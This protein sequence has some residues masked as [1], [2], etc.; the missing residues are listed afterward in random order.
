MHIMRATVLAALI[1]AASVSAQAEAP[2]P[3]LSYYALR[4][5]GEDAVQKELKL[6]ATQQ[7]K[8]ADLAGTPA[9]VRMSGWRRDGKSAAEM[10]AEIEK[11]LAF[12]KPDQRARLR[13]IGLQ[14]AEA[15]TAGRRVLASDK[16]LHDELKLTRAQREKLEGGAA[17]ADVLDAVQ[18]KALGAMK[19]TPMAKAGPWGE[20]G[21]KDARPKDGWGKSDKEKK[22]KAAPPVLQYLAAEAVAAELKLTKEQ[23][24]TLDTI[25]KKW[26]PTK[27]G[28]GKK[29][30][31]EPS[32]L[33][34]QAED[35]ARAALDA[36][37]AKR[38]GQIMLQA[39]AKAR[40]GGRDLFTL[41]AVLAVLRP[42]DEQRAELSGIMAAR[43]KALYAVIAAGKDVPDAV[44]K[45]NAETERR[46][47]AALTPEQREALASLV[48]EPFEADVPLRRFEPD[49]PFA[50]ARAPR[51]LLLTA[52]PFLT[53]PPLHAE[54]GLDAGQA[55]KLGELAVRARAA[56]PASQEVAAETAEAFEKALGRILK[57]AQLQRLREVMFQH[58]AAGLFGR[59]TLARII[60]ARQRLALTEDQIAK[61]PAARN[62]EDV[63][64]EA[65]KAA[66]KGM[67]GKPWDGSL[68]PARQRSTNL[69]PTLT[70]LQDAGV[71]ADLALTDAQK[72]R[73]AAIAADFEKAVTAR[74]EGRADFDA[75]LK[76]LE[77][78]RDAAEDAARKLL[79]PAQTKRRAELEMQQKAAQGMYNLLYAA[80]E[81]L[82]TTADQKKAITAAAADERALLALL[83]KESTPAD[84]LS[85]EYRAAGETIRS[86]SA[87]RM[88]AL[89]NDAQRTRLRGLL[90]KPFKGTL[91]G[92]R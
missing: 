57:P 47:R 54:L 27:T 15:L 46:L 32:K 89:L 21:K 87:L 83:R 2:R 88:E 30:R 84:Q 20:W 78:A 72:G 51:Y 65:Q 70:F 81:T 79:T 55:A 45:H 73:L 58:H 56:A 48:G 69:T 90:G 91:P 62:M 14:R 77:A 35:D 22:T 82:K 74:N 85:E 16:A 50:S 6:D 28:F 3:P 7:K 76:K 11:L 37:Q 66:W 64:T 33:A 19:G 59:A 31:D 18:K 1:L 5:L 40:R 39:E 80:A 44:R 71:S 23:R 29:G 75:Q 34:A 8:A 9:A 13:G 4:A 52:I 60:E 61:L 67:V 43:Q 36:G 42:T 25:E 53:H 63:L 17:L 92:A 12:L 38:L 24:R 10:A 49:G 26:S 41:P 86:G 68:T